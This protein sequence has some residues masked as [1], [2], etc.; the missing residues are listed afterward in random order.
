MRHP[1]VERLVAY[2]KIMLP[3]D[4]KLHEPAGVIMATTVE[5]VQGVLAI[6]NKYT[7]PIW[8]VSTGRNYGYGS[9]APATRGQMVLD[10]RC[11]NK[12]LEVDPEMCTALVEP[13][14]TY[15][16]LQDYLDEHDL[17]LWL[18]SK[19]GG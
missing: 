1:E 7:I 15:R 5:Q 8:P 14:V 9:A 3:E 16:Q 18:R 11:M 6:C 10:L 13:G 19:A 17:P 4:E 2:K 12:I